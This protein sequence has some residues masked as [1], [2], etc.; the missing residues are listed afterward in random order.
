MEKEKLERI[1]FL[2]HKKKSVGLTEHEALEQ[3]ALYAEYLAEIRM[4]F[5]ATLE[6]TVIKRPDGSVEPLKKKDH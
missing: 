3:Q 4:S 5:G 6:H 1:N 2:A